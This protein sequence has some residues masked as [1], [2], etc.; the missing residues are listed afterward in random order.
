MGDEPTRTKA[1][2]RIIDMFFSPAARA[3]AFDITVDT[4]T[5]GAAMRLVAR[6]QYVQY[7]MPSARAVRKISEILRVGG[8]CPLGVPDAH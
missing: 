8:W 7:S 2:T 5:Y 4:V 6:V 3:S 1:F